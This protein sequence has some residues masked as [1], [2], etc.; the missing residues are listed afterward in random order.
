MSRSNHDPTARTRTDPV[1]R[2]A[3]ERALR[4]LGDRA[5]LCESLSEEQLEEIRRYAGPEIS[6][7]HDDA[8]SE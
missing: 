7:S 5:G 4:I 6:G 3:Y 2:E 1:R 8:P